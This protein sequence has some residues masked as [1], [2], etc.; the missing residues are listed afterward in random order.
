MKSLL[1]LISI[2][3]GYKN[4][5]LHHA[6]NYENSYYL[7]LFDDTLLVFELYYEGLHG[8]K[9]HILSLDYYHKHLLPPD[10]E[11][12][13]DGIVS[14]LKR[15]VIPKNRTFVH[16]I[17]QSMGLEANDTKGIIDICKGLSLNDSY[18]VVPSDFNGSFSD[19][20]LYHNHFSDILALVAYTGK[21]HTH[22]GLST[23][24]EF[25]THGF[26][27]KAWRML[28]NDGIYLFKGGSEGAI[29]AGLE[30]YSEFYACQIA[31]KMGLTHVVYDLVK[32]KNILASKCKL[33]TDINTA[34]IPIG[35][36]VTHGGLKACLEF[37]SHIS[38]HAL[39]K[40]K[41]MLVFDAVIYNE[42]RHFGNFGVLMNSHSCKIFDAAPI[43]DNG[44]SLFNYALQNDIDNLGSYAKTRTNPYDLP[45][46]VICS[47]VLGNL[48]R[49][50]LKKLI[51]FTFKRHT[52]YNLPEKRLKV[53]EKHIQYR[54]R[55]LLSLPKNN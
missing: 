30:P 32:W 10:L 37:Y 18:W 53:I 12:S 2:P 36:L 41:S 50:Q 23:S 35:H 42:D 15:R 11:L 54:I 49:S 5:L 20:N 26:L 52:Q 45:Y 4:L 40:I 14:W 27:R 24:P 34:Y 51:G 47:E 48:Q 3:W 21:S 7:K 17:L 55:Q 13:N 39:E 19:F 46:E 1:H 6:Q 38:T 16:E 33:F 28:P 25:T 29:N 44:V 43:F 9:A 8:L 22:K 31:H